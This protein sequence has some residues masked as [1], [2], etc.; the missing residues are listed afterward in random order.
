M[1]VGAIHPYLS[2]FTNTISSLWLFAHCY[3]YIQIHHPYNGPV[4]W[5]TTWGVLTILSSVR[6]RVRVDGP[7][8]G[9]AR[10]G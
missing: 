10:G 7:A 9:R 3:D 5:L 4:Y 6:A 1:I 8:G 2:A